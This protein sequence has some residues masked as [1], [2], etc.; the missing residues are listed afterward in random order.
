M[1]HIW[2]M[3]EETIPWQVEVWMKQGRVRA[4]VYSRCSAF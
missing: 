2:Q 1:E 4:Y 3:L